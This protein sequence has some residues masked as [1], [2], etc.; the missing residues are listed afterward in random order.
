MTTA[1]IEGSGIC[2]AK[3][4]PI[5]NIKTLFCQKNKNKPF[6]SQGHTLHAILW[7]KTPFIC[8]ANQLSRTNHTAALRICWRSLACSF[9]EVRVSL[10]MIF[11]SS[12]RI[13]RNRGPFIYRAVQPG[14]PEPLSTPRS[15]RPSPEA[16]HR[17]LKSCS[18]LQQST[19]GVFHIK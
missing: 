14:P 12:K 1:V 18:P 10:I 19:Q 15:A 9:N 17:E 11:S 5:F 3:S 8:S 2:Q 16:T 6:K 13:Q 7:V 4:N